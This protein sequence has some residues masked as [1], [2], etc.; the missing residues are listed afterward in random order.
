MFDHDKESIDTLEQG[1][2]A[3]EAEISR[4]RHRQ[5]QT[6]RLLESAQ[7]AQMDGC[8]S[9]T[10]WISSRLDED[11]QTARALLALSRATDAGSQSSRDLAS[12]MISFPRAAAEANL[13]ELGAPPEVVTSSRGLDLSGLWR[14][15]GR[16]RRISPT[17]EQQTFSERYLALQPNLDSSSW[18]L[19]GQLAGADGQIVEAALYARGDAL[20][21]LP[22]ARGSVSERNADALVSISLD[23][24]TGTSEDE[25][26]DRTT[27]QVSVF[28]DASVAAASVGKAGLE[29]AAGPR[30]GP[31]ALSELLCNG[32]V[33]FT[34]LQGGTPLGV[35]R[36]SR[37]IPPRLRR[38][39][40]YRDGGCSI[41]GCSSRYR[42]QAHHVVPFS[43]GGKT[44]ADNLL[45]VCWYHHH[46]VIHGYGYRIDPESPPGRRRFLR[47]TRA[48]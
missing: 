48:P 18:R 27:A 44:E 46:V 15:V 41:E 5:A 33:D 36:T 6:L 10:E 22:E 14:L 26:E 9:M 37:V 4:L 43:E 11:P 8:R 42:L 30:I 20:G 25:G 3:D 35:G 40:L 13:R 24:L 12:G 34:L 45:T 21:T 17:E 23:S 31:E 28:V 1:L 32:R 47:R 39:V 2:L 38:Y 29:L 19:W 16:H 7:V